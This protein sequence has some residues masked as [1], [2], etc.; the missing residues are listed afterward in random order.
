MSKSIGRARTRP[1]SQANGLMRRADARM[2]N[3]PRH[4]RLDE[5]DF[6]WFCGSSAL[7]PDRREGVAQRRLI[8]VS[9]SSRDGPD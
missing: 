5:T 8:P 1:Q 2:R 9:V 3:G 6:G 4:T 7:L